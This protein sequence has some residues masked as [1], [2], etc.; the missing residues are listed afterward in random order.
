ML[1]LIL[2]GLVCTDLIHSSVQ[3][4]FIFHPNLQSATLS[5]ADIFNFLIFL[6]V[7]FIILVDALKKKNP[8]GGRKY[9]SLTR[10]EIYKHKLSDRQ[11]QIVWGLRMV[12]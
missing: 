7:S 8:G 2:V 9:W 11:G 6:A 4:R 3:E 5:N 12:A 10:Q 1:S